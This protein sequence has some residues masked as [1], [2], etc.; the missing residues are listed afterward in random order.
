MDRK[1]GQFQPKCAM[2]SHA[3]R[4]ENYTSMSS[5]YNRHKV[6]ASM[7]KYLID[8]G[9]LKTLRSDRES[10]IC[11][12]CILEIESKM[13][14][15][16]NHSH[17]CDLVQPSNPVTDNFGATVPTQPVSF[18]SERD[19]MSIQKPDIALFQE[20]ARQNVNLEI[21]SLNTY[22]YSSVWESHPCTI[23]RHFVAGITDYRS[24]KMCC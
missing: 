22:T 14:L 4:Q 10:L 15:E 2:V 18:D 3:E 12:C 17:S 5:I 13:K 11:N 1:K 16:E 24:S 6:S 20:M 23:F 9:L 7:K 8:N 19:T 21:N